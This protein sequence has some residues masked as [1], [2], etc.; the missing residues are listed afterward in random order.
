MI[1]LADDVV[2]L[3][4]KCKKCADGTEALFTHR[5]CGG[6]KQIMIGCDEYE[7]LCRNCYVNATKSNNQ[8]N[9]KTLSK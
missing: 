3:K 6:N 7:A 5:K 1:P 4:A 2:K 9:T 8:S